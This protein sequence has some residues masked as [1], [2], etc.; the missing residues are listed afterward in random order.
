MTPLAKQ[1][2]ARLKAKNLTVSALEKKAGLKNYTVRNIM[3]GKSRNPNFEMM[4]AICNV[5]GCSIQDLIEKDQH[6]IEVDEEGV[7]HLAEE[8]SFDNQALLLNCVETVNSILE[9][10]K[11]VLT[12][13]QVM[14]CIEEIYLHS[15]KQNLNTADSSFAKWFIDLT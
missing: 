15:H 1:I 5:L 9:K 14:T 8:I 6:F 3:R 11:Q 10:N 4:Q 7:E 13:R 12:V 2:S